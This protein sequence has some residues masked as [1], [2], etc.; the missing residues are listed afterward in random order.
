MSVELDI[1]YEQA[2]FIVR[3]LRRHLRAGATITG[4]P[5]CLRLQEDGSVCSDLT[6][7]YPAPGSPNTIGVLSK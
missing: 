3:E 4:S 2:A 7:V 6:V 5:N 1:P